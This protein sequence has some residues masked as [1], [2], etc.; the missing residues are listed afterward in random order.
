[1]PSP[2]PRSH[3]VSQHDEA[4]S[5]PKRAVRSARAIVVFALVLMALLSADLISKH[6]A[7]ERVAGDPVT[8]ER[9]EDGQLAPLPRHDPVV[10]IP[11]VLAFQ[12]TLNKGAVFGLGGGGRWVF[13]VFSVIASLVIAG[14]FARSSASSVLLH[15]TLGAILAGALGNLYDRLVYGVVRDLLLLFPGVKLPFGWT[16]PGGA[17]GLYPWIFNIADVCLVVGLITL[18]IITYR[19]DRAVQKKAKAEAEASGST[20]S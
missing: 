12:L 14:I 1:M 7:F 18:M 13:V 16:W 19:H 20:K 15:V 17:D 4:S 2:S 10:A 8:L 5:P 3:D 9:D 6:V 11:K